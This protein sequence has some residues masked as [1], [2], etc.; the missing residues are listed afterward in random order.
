MNK[1]YLGSFLLLILGTFIFWNQGCFSISSAISV[2]L[3]FGG[4]Y[5]LGGNIA[6]DKCFDEFELSKRRKRG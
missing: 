2:S 1:Y 3:I 6:I 4:A 5:G